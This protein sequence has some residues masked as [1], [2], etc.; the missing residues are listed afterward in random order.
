MSVIYFLVFILIFAEVVQIFSIELEAETFKKLKIFSSLLSHHA[1]DI[2][3]IVYK[4]R[5]AADSGDEA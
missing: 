1:R 4:R 3:F 2:H 5:I